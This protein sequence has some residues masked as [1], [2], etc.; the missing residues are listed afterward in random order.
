MA[1]RAIH[2]GHDNQNDPHKPLITPIYQTASYG[3]ETTEDLA[4]FYDKTSTRLSEYARYGTPTQR[5]LEETLMALEGAE[6]AVVTSSGMSAICAAILAVADTGSQIVSLNEGYRGTFKAFDQHLSRLGIHTDYVSLGLDAIKKA[7]DKNVRV[8]FIEI[9]TNP[10]LRLIDLTSAVALAKAKGITTVVDATFASPFNIQPLTYGADLVVHSVTKFL[11]GHNDTVAGAVLGSKELIEKVRGVRGLL[12][13]NPDAHQCYLISRGIKTFPLRMDAHNRSALQIATYLEKHP[14][15]ERVWYP[16]L[17][18]HPDFT[19]AQKYLKGGGG[20]VSFCVKAKNSSQ[21]ARFSAASAFL[22]ALT[23]PTIGAS[24]GGVE[25][26]IH[27]VSVMSYWDMDSAA[28][29]KASIQDNL[30][31]FSVGLEDTED[32]INDLANALEKI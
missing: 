28:R 14:K 31:R 27:Q 15:I 30:I 10:F 32:L 25:S 11:N 21:E 26:L 23:I 24:L 2:A 12:G 3:F 22:N 13:S 5:A 16:M 17:T 4:A 9:P 20:I 8:L 19:L 18:S 7:L 6:D 29:L 1:T